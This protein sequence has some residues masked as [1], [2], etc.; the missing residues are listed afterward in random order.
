MRH[1]TRLTILLALSA[2]AVAVD[3]SE[4][5]GRVVGI[6]DGDTITVLDAGKTQHKIRLAGIDAPERGQPGAVRSTESS[7]VT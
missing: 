2:V 3:A 5:V 1:A 4:L 7:A 6:T